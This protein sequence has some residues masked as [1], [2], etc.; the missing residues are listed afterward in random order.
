[1]IKVLLIIRFDE[2]Y[3]S[4]WNVGA[5]YILMNGIFTLVMFE[6]HKLS[7]GS[8]PGK[9][10]FSLSQ[11]DVY[12]IICPF[13]VASATLN[14]PQIPTDGAQCCGTFMVFYVL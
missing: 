9:C 14:S 6:E 12:I 3:F 7:L 5:K 8:L 1:M 10:H 13:S 4:V 11:Q 2:T